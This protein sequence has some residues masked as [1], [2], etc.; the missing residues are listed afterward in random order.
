[1]SRVGRSAAS[2]CRHRRRRKFLRGGASRRADANPP[3]VHERN[4]HLRS[5]GGGRSLGCQNES[6]RP[7]N[8]ASGSWS[9]RLGYMPIPSGAG[10]AARAA[11]RTPR[12][13]RRRRTAF[14]TRARRA[15]LRTARFTFLLAL[16]ALLG[17]IVD[18]L[19][20][21]VLRGCH[22]SDRCAEPSAARGKRTTDYA[23]PFGR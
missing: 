9:R 4:D 10:A 5:R 18:L 8:S 7:P 6:S 11:L 19:V 12:R 3:A 14:F 2:W 16:F 22:G 17:A 21:S 23:H 13:T 20:E 1:P 15:P